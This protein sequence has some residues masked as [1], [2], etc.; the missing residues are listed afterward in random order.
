MLHPALE[1]HHSAYK[2]RTICITGGA[3]FI[4]SHIADT[5][6]ECGAT[7]RILDDFSNGRESN[8]AGAAS[9]AKV[10]RGSICDDAAL[11]AAIAGAEIVFHQAA[12]GSVPR[13][14]EIPAIYHEANVTGTMRVL[15]ASLRHGVRRVVYGPLNR[16]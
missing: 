5:L 1:A 7:V 16:G 15:E 4:G 11:D 14:I 8:L 3:G 2:G 12:M 10:V 13:S 6:V 9:A